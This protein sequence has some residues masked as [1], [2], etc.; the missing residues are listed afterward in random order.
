MTRPVHLGI[1]VGGTASRFVA[2]DDAGCRYAVAVPPPRAEGNRF[3]GDLLLAPGLGRERSRLTVTVGTV[4]GEP[5]D[6]VAIDSYDELTDEV[7][8]EVFLRLLDHL[9]ALRDE[10]QRRGGE[11]R[12]H[13]WTAAEL[14]AMRRIVRKAAL[15][16]L[17][18]AEAL[19]AM[20]S[21]EW[22]DLATVHRAA[23]LTGRGN[24]LKDVATAIGFAWDVEDPGG[25]FSML[26]HVRAVAG[27]ADAI[28]WLRAYNRSDVLATYEV[29]RWLRESF[30]TLPR[31]EDWVEP[32]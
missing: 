16:G 8:A 9:A 28:G 29:R 24:G 32:A 17:P 30:D 12:V 7:E 21:T 10:A 27:D 1:D 18:S 23:V 26:Q 20:I 5:G 15:P 4:A 2:C 3:D 19:E 13:H 11:L 31:V 14:T 22:V 25:D 6:Y